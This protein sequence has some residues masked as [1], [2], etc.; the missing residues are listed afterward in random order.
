MGSDR[1][2]WVGRCRAAGAQDFDW[3]SSTMA[4]SGLDGCE[5]LLD[6]VARS[7]PA[8]HLSRAFAAGD[9]KTYGSL[10]DALKNFEIAI[11]A[12]AQNP[13]WMSDKRSKWLNYCNNSSN[14]TPTGFATAALALDLSVPG[15]NNS[16]GWVGGTRNQW[17][18]RCRNAGATDFDWS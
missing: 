11:K 16:P 17:V 2:G 3:D 5:V 10:F 1:S 9:Y 4:V 15:E 14:H 13:D 7:V 12:S 8:E 18:T 6:Q